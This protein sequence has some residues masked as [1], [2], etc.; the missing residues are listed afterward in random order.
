M[1]T[2]LQQILNEVGYEFIRATAKHGPH[3][4]AHESY[5]VLCEEMD[6]FFD[7]VKK[8]TIEKDLMRKELIHVASTAVRAIYDLC[9]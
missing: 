6:E 4:S 8:Q 1:T 2:P 3:R 5:G 9:L 7:E